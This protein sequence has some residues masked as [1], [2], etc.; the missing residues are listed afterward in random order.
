MV[1]GIW[2]S[3][4]PYRSGSSLLHRDDP[5][6][7]GRKRPHRETVAQCIHVQM[8][9]G[10]RPDVHREP[11]KDQSGGI[12]FRFEEKP[13]GHGLHGLLLLLPTP[14]ARTGKQTVRIG[15]PPHI[16]L[17]QCHGRGLQDLAADNEEDEIKMI[18]QTPAARKNFTFREDL[19][20]EFDLDLQDNDA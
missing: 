3:R 4:L 12:L 10:I 7:Q 13:G 9:Q 11:D 16:R 17:A 19:I 20:K 5:S 14:C 1:L 2:L 18:A 6:P 8:Q 15:G